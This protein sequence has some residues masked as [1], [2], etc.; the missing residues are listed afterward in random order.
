MNFHNNPKIGASSSS[1]YTEAHQHVGWLF[2]K[3]TDLVSGTPELT[4]RSDA[5]CK[6]SSL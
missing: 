6:N 2:P 4:R 5:L 1:F 3:V